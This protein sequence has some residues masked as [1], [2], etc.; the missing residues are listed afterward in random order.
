MNLEDNMLNKISP[1]GKYQRIFHLQEVS[2]GVKLKE[3]VEQ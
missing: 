1:K 3:T 2:N